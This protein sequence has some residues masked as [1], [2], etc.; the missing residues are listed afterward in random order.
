MFSDCVR[1]S[2]RRVSGRGSRDRGLNEQPTRNEAL[3]RGAGKKI[4]L[5]VDDDPSFRR[6][7]CEALEG[8]GYVTVGAGSGRDAF[9]LLFKG[10]V[11]PDLILTDLRMS[12]VDGFEFQSLLATDDTLKRI[13]VLVISGAVDVT[14]LSR[15]RGRP[16]LAKPVSPDQML[17]KVAQYCR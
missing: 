12:D 9:D 16:F 11:K 7:L 17:E 15:L 10:R 3:H 2:K 14:A 5:V 13:P 6:D 4:V 8:A 1:M